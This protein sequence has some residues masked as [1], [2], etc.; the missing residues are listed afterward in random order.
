MHGAFIPQG[1][2]SFILRREWLPGHH[3]KP[4]QCLPGVGMVTLLRS[5]VA[6]TQVS[7]PNSQQGAV[8]EGTSVPSSGGVGRSRWARGCA[9]VSVMRGVHTHAGVRTPLYDLLPVFTPCAHLPF[10]FP[11]CSSF[12]SFSPPPQ[13]LPPSSM[14]FPRRPNEPAESIPGIPSDDR[15]LAMQK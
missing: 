12:P 3:A 6:E 9:H 7:L 15:F 1:D 4:P 10:G 5:K 2:F 11:N 13:T 8:T 14:Y